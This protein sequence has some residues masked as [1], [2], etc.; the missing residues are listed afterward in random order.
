MMASAAPAVVA[1][2]PPEAHSNDHRSHWPLVAVLS[3]V[4]V[5]AVVVGLRKVLVP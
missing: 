1:P 5:G 3:V 4:V 2:G